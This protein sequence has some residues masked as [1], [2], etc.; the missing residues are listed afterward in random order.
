M[1]LI[2][3]SKIL[4]EFKM[5]GNIEL[6]SLRDENDNSL[7][8]T[9]D[10]DLHFYKRQRRFTN[11]YWRKRILVCILIGILII[12]TVLFQNVF[13]TLYTPFNNSLSN[14]SVPLI[15][16][17]PLPPYRS[18]SLPPAS[19]TPFTQPPS[20]IVD[21]FTPSTTTENHSLFCSGDDKKCSSVLDIKICHKPC[22]IVSS[23]LPPGFIEKNSQ[24]R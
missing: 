2:R 18:P 17:H 4:V 9:S 10:D 22:F 20:V 13:F 11:K 6:V 1:R 24:T 14:M 5:V 19:P 3:Y 21:K 7:S 12:G 23:P 8:T 16:S 15:E